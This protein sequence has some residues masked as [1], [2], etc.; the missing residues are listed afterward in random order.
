M[1]WSHLRS[2]NTNF[3]PQ[4]CEVKA[5]YLTLSAVAIYYMKSLGFITKSIMLELI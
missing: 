4:L 3:M 5:E 1:L 2:E